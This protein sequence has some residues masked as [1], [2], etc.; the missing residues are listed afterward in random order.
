MTRESFGWLVAGV[1][2]VIV[3]SMGAVQQ[4]GRV[5]RFQIVHVTNPV[6]TLFEDGT[7]ETKE[8]NLTL[9]LDTETGETRLLTMLIKEDKTPPIED[10]VN[11]IWSSEFVTYRPPKP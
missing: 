10:P 5:G 7:L 8:K 1:S 11:G 9:M 6:S 2:V 4:S 3:A